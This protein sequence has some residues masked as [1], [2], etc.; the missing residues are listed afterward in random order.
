MAEWRYAAGWVEHHASLWQRQWNMVPLVICVS[1][2]MNTTLPRRQ[3]FVETVGKG[4]GTVWIKW[5][6]CCILWSSKQLHSGNVE[7]R[8]MFISLP[9]VWDFKFCSIICCLAVHS[10]QNSIRSLVLGVDTVNLLWWQQYLVDVTYLF[11]SWLVT[12]TC[13][14]LCS[15][16]F[17][18]F[19]HLKVHHCMFQPMWS[20]SGVKIF[21]E[22]TAVFSCCLCC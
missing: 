3:K 10:S 18:N 8:V 11:W 12:V 13:A 4:M 7:V 15:K 2:W 5:W 21:G 1:A 22:E 16:E 19:K 9:T 6:Q 14:T 20:S 17:I